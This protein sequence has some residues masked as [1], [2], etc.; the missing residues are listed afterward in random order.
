VLPPLS[1]SR[2]TSTQPRRRAYHS[3][4]R[5][6]P[7][8]PFGSAES[9]ILAAALARVPSHGFSAEALALG[10]RDA[11]YL[12]ISAGLVPEGAFGLV[13][14]HLVTQREGLAA[15]AEELFAAP[16]G[17]G[18]R[19]L[20]TPEKAEALVWERLMGNREVVGRWQEVCSI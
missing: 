13:R 17:G 2:A 6:A 16:A 1:P 5:P 14:W 4:D 11:G 18:T 12:D 20:S 8:G 7:A 10:A 19:L 9:A 15:R 3:Y